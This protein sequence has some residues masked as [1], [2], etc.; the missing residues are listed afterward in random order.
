MTIE[1]PGGNMLAEFT[2]GSTYPRITLVLRD[3]DGGIER[4]RRTYALKQGSE[5]PERITL[6]ELRSVV[7]IGKAPLLSWEG[8]PPAPPLSWKGDP[9]G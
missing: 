1:A 6:A 3:T 7:D 8:D 5:P 2:V 9:P 4:G